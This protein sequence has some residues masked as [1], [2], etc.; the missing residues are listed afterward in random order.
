MSS[1]RRLLG[2]GLLAAGLVA[3]YLPGVAHAKPSPPVIFTGTVKP[4]K[5]TL[6]VTD[7]S[8]GGK[9]RLIVIDRAPD[10][11]IGD[12]VHAIK[13]AEAPISADGGALFRPSRPR[14]FSA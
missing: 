5:S 10:S 8:R 2:V 9:V 14:I 6:S 12:E 13:V 4:P 11:K 1:T 7:V 3:G